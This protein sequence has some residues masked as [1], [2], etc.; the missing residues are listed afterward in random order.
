MER[1]LCSQ[2]NLILR[3]KRSL[4]KII[5]GRLT[6]R[7]C[8]GEARGWM[9]ESKSRVI[10]TIRGWPTNNKRKEVRSRRLEV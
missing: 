2:K 9:V 8:E 5:R 4:N 7:N 1:L 10:D 6:N 3:I